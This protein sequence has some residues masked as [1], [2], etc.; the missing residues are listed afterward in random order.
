VRSPPFCASDA[1]SVATNVDRLARASSSVATEDPKIATDVAPDVPEA[2]KVAIFVAPVATDDASVVPEATFGTTDVASVVQEASKVVPEDASVATE[3]DALARDV[4]S[5]VNDAALLRNFGTQPKRKEFPVNQNKSTKRS[6]VSLHLPEPVPALVTY[7][8]SVVTAMTNNPNFTT[9]LPS[10]ADVSAA[11][12]ALLTAETAA[13]SRLKGTVV[14]RND[15]KAALVTLLQELRNYV[16]KT[17]DADQENG[18]AIIQSSGFPVRKTA[19]H[20]PRTFAAEPGPVSGSVVVTAQAAA[21]RA[22]YEWQY[23]T[24]GGKTWIEAA[25]SLKSRT[26]ILGLPVASAVQI[27]SRAVTKAGPSDWTQPL[28]VVVK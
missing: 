2:T 8:Q 22:S 17:A 10:L 1:S 27:R 19:V 16:Q 14:V 25:P 26:T 5:D 11:I 15:K 4:A 23:S 13:L 20:K 3:D 28:V 18:A 21:R 7:S 9:P 6:L 24:D 12:A